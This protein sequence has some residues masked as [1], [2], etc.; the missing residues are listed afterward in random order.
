MSIS[1]N[2]RPGLLALAVAAAAILAAGCG[3]SAAQPTADAAP[4]AKVPSG[5]VVPVAY[6]G[7]QHRRYRYGPITIRP[8]QNP[9]VFEPNMQKP[10][11]PGYITRFRPDLVYTNGKKP[12]VD[13]LHLHHG[14]WIMRQAPTFAVGEEKTITQF[15]RGFGYRYDPSDEWILNYMLHNLTPTTAQVYITWDVDFVPAS[16]PA[17]ADI[18]EVKPLW[19]DVGRGAYPVFDAHRG[20]GKDGRYTFPDDAR[21]AERAKL[22]PL[23]HITMPA[24]ATLVAAGGH[25]HPGGLWVD[26]KST[27]GAQTKTIFRSEAKY[28]EPAGAVSWDA[29]MTFTKPDWRVAVRKGD[30]LSVSATYDTTRASWYEVMGIVD[31][32]WYTTKTI[33]GAPD[34]FEQPV[35]W[36]GVV[37]HGHL[38]ENDNHGGTGSAALPDARTLRAGAPRSSVNIKQF[39]YAL[40]DLT[41][42]GAS[43]RPPTVRQGGTLAFRNLDSP[44]GQDF[45]RAIY[46]TITACKSPCNKATGIAYPLADGKGAFDS[47]ELGYGPRQATAAANR[48]TWKTPRTLS[49]GTYSYFCRV[50]PFM[51]GA[52]RVT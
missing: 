6:S 40:G 43:G 51:R 10:S 2:I 5:V 26:L 25:V 49:P 19:L 31:P 15:P 20:W 45:M 12:A 17:A 50:H 33:A 1:R 21:G 11:V 13:V 23:Q 52:F 14:V 22:G 37:T 27:R 29:S 48:V 16:A 9:I 39:V 46:H 4:A 35:D 41:G 24:D 32:L 38:P 42:A 8:G 7:V 47:G 36:H 3:G 18:A 44:K 28:Y 34:P 30:T